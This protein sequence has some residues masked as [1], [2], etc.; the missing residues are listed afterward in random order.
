MGRLA[1]CNESVGL[2]NLQPPQ[3]ARLLWQNRKDI[4]TTKERNHANH[5][6][7]WNVIPLAKIKSEVVA[8]THEVCNSS[9]SFDEFA[10]PGSQ[11]RANK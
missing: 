2:L 6:I 5:V 3:A 7:S 8:L 1:C 10:L 4:A 11:W 9:Y